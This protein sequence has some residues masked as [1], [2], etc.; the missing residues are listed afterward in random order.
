MR[1]Y[2]FSLPGWVSREPCEDIRGTGCVSVEFRNEDC[3]A[4]AKEYCQ[5]S[6]ANV[7]LLNMAGAW[8]WGG[9]VMR[10]WNSQEQHL[11]RCSNLLAHLRRA[12]ADGYY[13][14][15]KWHGDIPDFSVLV[16]KGVEFFKH[17]RDYVTLPRGERFQVGVLTAVVEKV[18]FGRTLGANV[19]RFIGFMLDIVLRHGCTH[20]VL[21]AWGCG[22]LGQCPYSVAEC[23]RRNFVK[24]TQARVQVAFA[25]VDD[26]NSDDNLAAF[27]RVFRGCK[28]KAEEA[29]LRIEFKAVDAYERKEWNRAV[30]QDTLA[31][32][33]MYPELQCV[34]SAHPYILPGNFIRE[35]LEDVSGTGRVR[36]E[37]FNAD[38]VSVA[39]EYC[40]MNGANVWLLNMAHASNAGGGVMGGC[41][42]QEEHLCRCSNL[43]LHLKGALAD[44][45]YPL[46]KWHGSY[47]DFSVL[48][49]EAVVF[50]KHPRDYVTLSRGEWFQVGVLTAAA[51]K[52][53]I[54]RTVG[55]NAER[56]IGFML[57]TALRQGCTH[58]VLSAWG[59]GAFGQCPHAVAECFRRTFAKVTYTNLQVAFAI[60]D[61]HNSDD[62]LAAFSASSSD[63]SACMRMRRVPTVLMI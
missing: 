27:K 34:T 59:C 63:L 20:L 52:V 36:V 3:V 9:G 49:H 45:Y 5:I 29:L 17:P 50:F 22:A 51:E 37:V 4:V 57:D 11:F 12:S 26:E 8:S 7:W 55:R 41:N 38:C 61:D 2:R 21:S 62:N 44:G 47:L 56:F 54:R 19:E 32:C 14:L 39:K 46:H 23:F 35:P 18:E 6:G 31:R 42:A 43:L 25:V 48:A 24:V 58:L 60:L 30:I 16:H 28:R 10:G 1:A 53:R 15:H 33:R 40:Q 13:P